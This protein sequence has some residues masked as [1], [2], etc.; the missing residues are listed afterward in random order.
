MKKLVIDEIKNATG[1]TTANAEIAF[2]QVVDGLHSAVR[3]NDEVRIPGLGT[4]K[5][6]YRE[7]RQGRNPATGEAIQIA[8]REVLKFKPAKDAI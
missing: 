2:K 5:K 1:M 6:V 3:N 7:G 4:F 8:G